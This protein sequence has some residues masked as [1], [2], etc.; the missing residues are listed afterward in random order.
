MEAP[1]VI[2][3]ML[4]LFT[5]AYAFLI[6][7][8]TYGWFSLKVFDKKEAGS[9]TKI[10][11]IVPARN[12]ANNI[13]NCLSGLLD[14]TY[15]A[16]RYDII[17]VDDHSSD[18]TAQIVNEVISS[19]KNQNLSL[20]RLDQEE[21]FGKKYAISKAVAIAKG[22][23]IVTTD[24]DCRI[25]KT[26]LSTIASFYEFGK[27]K[28][29]SGPVSFHDEKSWFEKLQSLEFLSLISSGA[30][31]ISVNAPILCNGA[32]LAYEKSAFKRVNG[33][34]S[35]G[36]FMSGD[37]IFLMLKIYKLFGKG[38]VK[39][40]KSREAIVQTKAQKTIGSFIA[41]RIRWVSKSRAYTN[42][43]IINSSLIVFLFNYGILAGT[44]LGIWFPELL[45]ASAFLLIL[46]TIIDLP[47]LI[48][49]SLFSGKQNLLINI[50]P[51]QILYILYVSVVGLIGNFV[52]FNWKGR[53]SG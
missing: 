46:K 34:D 4:Y 8:Y 49:V 25:K 19:G 47:L 30:G 14:Q 43:A 15:P 18:D 44:I 35:D 42:L 38:S 40:L 29:I 26:W 11:V 41:Q 13:R 22:N 50:L 9:Q 39:F 28:L 33:F 6:G 16:D 24:A 17:V 1:I 52:K 23:L 10:S 31:S 36:K 51:L 2:L 20:V 5:L 7:I 45:I 3:F 27:P 53:R 37:D 32:N 12:E 21:G 48:G